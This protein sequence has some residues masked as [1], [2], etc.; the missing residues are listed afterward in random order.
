MAHVVE[1]VVEAAVVA[2]V[3]IFRGVEA[4]PL[5]VLNAAD[6]LF[7]ALVVPAVELASALVP[8]VVLPSA[9]VCGEVLVVLVIVLGVSEHELLDLDSFV[10]S[11]KLIS[12]RWPLWKVL[13]FVTKEFAD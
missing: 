6:V 8:P 3:D 4:F 1:A 13:I 7:P 9:V 12:S 5:F 2:V 11:S 10:F